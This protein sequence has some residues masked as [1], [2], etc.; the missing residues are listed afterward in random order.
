MKLRAAS[1]LAVV[2]ILGG[3]CGSSTSDPAPVV[4]MPAPPPTDMPA[5]TTPPATPP[6]PPPLDHGAVSTKYPAF[7]P[8]TGQIQTGGGPVLA[9]PVVVTVTWP[10]DTRATDLETFGDTIGSGAY[11]TAIASEYGASAAVSGAANHLRLTDPAPASFTDAQLSKFISDNLSAAGTTWPIPTTG[12][13]VYVL[14]LPSTTEVVLQGQP[15]CS[16]DVGGYH[17]SVNVNGKPVAYAIIP[18]CGNAPLDDSTLT[19]SHEI[20]E[21]TTDPY[22]NGA[23]AYRGFRE[24][25]LAWQQFLQNQDEVGDACE[26]FDDSVLSPGDSVGAPAFVVQRQWSNA[27]GQAGHDPCVPEFTGE[28][29]FNTTPLDMEDIQVAVQNSLTT[30][31]GY[32]IP[33]GTKRQIPLGFYSE[34][35]TAPWTIKAVNAT[36]AGGALGDDITLSID[37]TSGQNGQKAYLTVAVKTASPSNSELVT[38][39]SKLGGVTRYMPFLIGN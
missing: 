23:A 37:V 1:T 17:D 30:T 15:T 7:T 28:V 32:K 36:L 5:A 4:T 6:P 11:W 19:A 14:Y 35:A 9:K 31:K 13:P 21:A 34:G 25:D 10:G 2:A 24:E 12:D 26:F 16:G 38:I 29:Y 3:A 18:R 20:D 33:A 27:S 22:P 39:V 8:A